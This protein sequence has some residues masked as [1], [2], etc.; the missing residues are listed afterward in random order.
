VSVVRVM[1]RLVD[2]V[3]ALE[4]EGVSHRLQP[5][6]DLGLGEAQGV[7]GEPHVELWVLKVYSLRA[8]YYASIYLSF[9][10][11]ITRLW[12]VVTLQQPHPA[13]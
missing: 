3:Q 2:Q 10:L 4:L 7:E 6:V 8:H 9:M 11:G 5:E 1:W 12:D 13:L